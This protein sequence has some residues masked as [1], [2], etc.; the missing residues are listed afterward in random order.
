MI[1]IQACEEHPNLDPS[2]SHV[3]QDRPK[4]LRDKFQPKTAQQL[5]VATTCFL[6][7]GLGFRVWGLGFRV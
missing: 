7:K 5:E 4:Q 1:P 6:H 3:E 2:N